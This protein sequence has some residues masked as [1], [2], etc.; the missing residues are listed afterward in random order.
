VDAPLPDESE[1][2]AITAP[3]DAADGAPA[4]AP[5]HGAAPPPAYDPMA[6]LTVDPRRG[7][8][9]AG[10]APMAAGT[11]RLGIGAA[12]GWFASW[13]GAKPVLGG[14]GA[15]VEVDAAWAPT[16]RV[17]FTATAGAGTGTF[18][19]GGALA[20]LDAT[21]GIVAAR[22]LAVDAPRVRVAPF[23]AGGLGV[24][25]DVPPAAGTDPFA[26]PV[27]VVGAG[28]ALEIP[29]YDVL[30]DAELPVGGLVL[31]GELPDGLPLV[32]GPYVPLFLLTEVGFTWRLGP[33]TSFRLGYLAVATSWSWRYRHDHFTLEVSGYTNVLTGS[34]SARAG[35]A[36]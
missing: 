24:V 23:V 15:G 32:A 12:G 25:A 36:F 19:T 34:L 7:I 35:W 17:A 33:D 21:G 22:W 27:A 1:V 18:R 31:A 3:A 8:L 29:F 9:W 20:P 13:A 5:A 28:V 4:I 14:A 11:G 2:P 10:A 26:D 16:R 30:V 6:P